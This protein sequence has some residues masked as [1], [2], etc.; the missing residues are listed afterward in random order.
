[1]LHPDSLCKPTAEGPRAT[2]LPGESSAGCILGLLLKSRVKRQSWSTTQ[3]ACVLH[4]GHDVKQVPEPFPQI[5]L[6]C[7]RVL[8][9]GMKVRYRVI[10]LE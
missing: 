3:T 8:Q 4:T 9:T 7:L 5:Y 1:M 6:P 2:A 10:D